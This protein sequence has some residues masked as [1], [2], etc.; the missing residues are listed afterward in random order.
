MRKLFLISLV[1][2][3]TVAPVRRVHASV[4]AG[5]LWIQPSARSAGMADCTVAVL[6]DATAASWNP[7]GL[8]FLEGDLSI[9]GMYTQLVP[10]WDDV[11]YWHLAP[12]GRLMPNLVVGGTFLYL[13]YG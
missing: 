4:G 1:V 7:G 3:A 2:F 13:T 12:A 10:D 9:V 5:S 11:Y 6:T 8:A